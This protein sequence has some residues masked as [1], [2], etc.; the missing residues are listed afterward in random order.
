M[1][2]THRAAAAT[3]PVSVRVTKSERAT[4]AAAAKAAGL[5]VSAWVRMVALATARQAVF[6]FLK[7]EKKS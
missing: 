6:P 4:L 5:D 3:A 7:K 1:S 2:R